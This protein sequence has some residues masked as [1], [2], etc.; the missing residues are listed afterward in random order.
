MKNLYLI[1][2]LSLFTLLIPSKTV[3]A[4]CSNC[5][6]GTSPMVIS[7]E[8]THVLDTLREDDS[9]RFDIMQFNPALG[10]LRCVEVYS[11]LTGI[12]TMKLENDETYTR[13]YA[14]TYTRNDSV[15]GPGLS[16]D[17][18]NTF[19]KGYG[20]YVLAP[21][22]DNIF[23]GPDYIYVGPDTVLKQKYMSR[24]VTSSIM[25]F[26][27]YGNLT[28]Y[29]KTGGKTTVTGSTNYI[30]Q[31]RSKNTVTIGVKYYYCQNI[32]LASTGLQYLGVQKLGNNK[33]RL[34]WTVKNELPDDNYRLEISRNGRDFIP[35]NA[36]NSKNAHGSSL[37]TYEEVYNAP[38]NGAYYFRVVQISSNGKKQYSNIQLVNME[39]GSLPRM[40]VS[41]NPITSKFKLEFDKPMNGPVFVELRNTAGQTVFSK[42]IDL[43]EGQSTLLDLN[44]V[45][46]AGVYYLNAREL[47]GSRSFGA[48]VMV[49]KGF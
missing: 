13:N 27:G 6:G 7:Y 34:G 9:A 10:E 47:K 15:Q 2:F 30:F 22:D 18:N 28:Y 38:G 39:E 37:A 11:Y 49:G 26:Q 5:S 4:Q 20:P 33:L 12:I 14:V 35:L 32:V 3:N 42:N 1:A 19:S 41:P 43:I 17:L 25:P 48:K 46:P 36:Y 44:T 21:T 24:N 31:I 8:V 29:Y 45:P 40:T 16:R 23:S